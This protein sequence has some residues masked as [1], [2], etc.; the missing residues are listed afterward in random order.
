[1]IYEQFITDTGFVVGKTVKI[2]NDKTILVN[3]TIN[4]DGGRCDYMQMFSDEDRVEPRGVPKFYLYSET[5]DGKLVYE[6]HCGTNDI[7]ENIGTGVRG[8][9]DSKVYEHQVKIE[10]N[11]PFSIHCPAQ[12][13]TLRILTQYMLCYKYRY[14]LDRMVIEND[15]VRLTNLLN[16]SLYSSGWIRV[17]VA[18]IR[19]AIL[20]YFESP[21]GDTSRQPVNFLFEYINIDGIYMGKNEMAVSFKQDDSVDAIYI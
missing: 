20:A 3:V 5:Y 8:I 9:I 6:G 10:V 11:S 16:M 17:S 2:N 12:E 13:T 18:R 4:A 21:M 19:P 7:L 14:G 15:L 1:M